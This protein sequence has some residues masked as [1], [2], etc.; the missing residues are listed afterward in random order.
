MNFNRIEARAFL[1]AAAL[2][3]MGGSMGG[4]GMGI[5]REGCC[6]QKCSRPVR[7]STS[8]QAH[9]GDF[10]SRR[11]IAACTC[12]AS[13]FLHAGSS[14]LA[15]LPRPGNVPR[16]QV[17]AA[18]ALPMRIPRG[19]EVAA[20]PL[21]WPSPIEVLTNTEPVRVFEGNHR[22]IPLT[23]RNA[24]TRRVSTEVSAHVFQTSSATVVPVENIE[25]KHLDVLAGQ[26]ILETATCNF[27]AV[28]AET[29]FLLEWFDDAQRLMGRTQVLVYPTNLLYEL[30]TVPGKT[31]IGVFDPGGAF[32]AGLKSLAPGF[33]ELDPTALGD[34]RGGLA[35]LVLPGASPRLHADL[36][37]A[38]SELAR[39]GVGVV[40][41]RRSEALPATVP[42]VFKI[43]EGKSMLV[44]AGAELV[45]GLV[46]SPRA[47]LNL[48]LLTRLALGREPVPWPIDPT[49]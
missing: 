48:L 43:A 4:T 8:F 34:F 25:W 14:S 33:V 20:E 3:G 7:A 42:F 6:G 38:V 39:K 37:A 2:K 15:W 19:A 47:Q 49:L 9:R 24:G 36:A 18:P 23:L 35:I 28:R 16:L 40:W 31:S 44:V 32:K 17:A 41:I 29:P 12:F 22:E 10:A 46:D 13:L 45:A 26:T 1:S 11:C 21:S 27:P 5:Q 30:S